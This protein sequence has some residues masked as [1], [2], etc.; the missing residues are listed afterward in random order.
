MCHCQK[1]GSAE[2]EEN[3]RVQHHSRNVQLL[4]RPRNRWI[5]PNE[6][7]RKMCIRR[8]CYKIKEAKA[9]DQPERGEALV[10]LSRKRRDRTFHFCS[11]TE[12]QDST[13]T[14]ISGV[15]LREPKKRWKEIIYIREKQRRSTSGTFLRGL[16]QKTCL[17]LLLMNFPTVWKKPGEYE[18]VQ[19]ENTSTEVGIQRWQLLAS[20]KFGQPV[21]KWIARQETKEN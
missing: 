21:R 3:W 20:G 16:G 14:S 15:H 9:E 2:D 10:S 1:R 5:K 18:T 11:R 13:C 17:P 8:R 12:G 4:L 6:I 7:K 19:A